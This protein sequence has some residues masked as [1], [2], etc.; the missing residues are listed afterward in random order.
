MYR[1]DSRKDQNLPKLKLLWGS[2]LGEKSGF[3]PFLGI[4]PQRLI[5]FLHFS[6]PFPITRL[7]TGFRSRGSPRKRVRHMEIRC[8]E[9][10]WHKRKCVKENW[11]KRAIWKWGR[12]GLWLEYQNIN[13]EKKTK[14]LWV[15]WFLNKFFS[16]SL[17]FCLKIEQRCGYE[18]LG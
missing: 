9:G 13:T 17:F 1:R 11:V 6:F 14:V 7:F 10:Q 18:C 5:L 8:R 3:V 16:L 2:R 15:L 12:L 4:I